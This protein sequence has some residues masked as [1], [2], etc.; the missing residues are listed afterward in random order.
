MHSSRQG[1]IYALTDG[2]DRVMY[3]YL[4]FPGYFMEIDYEKYIPKEC[5]PDGI[6]LTENNPIRQKVLEERENDLERYKEEQ[7]KKD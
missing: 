2:A 4:A 1:F 5:L 7:K 3:V 6:D